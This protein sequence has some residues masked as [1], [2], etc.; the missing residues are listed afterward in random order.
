[1]ADLTICSGETTSLTISAGPQNVAGTTF[2]WTA[3]PSA[4]VS[5]SSSGNGSLIS[6]T[7]QTTNAI[8]GSVSYSITPTA[9]GCNGP[10]HVLTVTV[11]PIATVSAGADFAVCEPVSFE[12]KGFLG[13][14]AT[15]GNWSVV[16]PASGSLSASTT[17][18]NEV[19][20]I[21]TISSADIDGVITFRLT[22]NDPD[23]A[24]P[25]VSVS[26]DVNVSINRRAVV[27]LPA[28]YTLCEP[29]TIGLS[30]TLSGSATSAIW[31]TASTGGLSTTSI[32]GPGPTYTAAATYNT[33]AADVT[34]TLTFRLTTNDPDASGPCT[35]EFAEIDIHINESAKVNADLL[36]PICD[37]DT[38]LLTGS[39]SGSA[40]SAVWTAPAGATGI[41]QNPASLSTEYYHTKSDLAMKTLTFTLTTNDPDGAGP[42]VSSSDDVT[43]T[44]NKLDPVDL[45]NLKSTYA[46]NE[47]I[48]PLIAFPNDPD[49]GSGVFTGPGIIAGTSLFDPGNA[50]A[51]ATNIITYTWQN[52]F[53]GCINS[54]SDTTI[55]NALTVID[56]TIVGSTESDPTEI[57]VCR[58]SG[59]LWIKGSPGIHDP[60]TNESLSEFQSDEIPERLLQLFNPITGFT[61]YYLNTDG[62]DP[63]GF[64]TIRYYHVD[65]LGSPQAMIKRIYVSASPVADITMGPACLQD[66]VTFLQNSTFEPGLNPE[67]DSVVQYIW[68]FDENGE[69]EIVNA[70]I[71]SHPTYTYENAGPHLV[72]LT[73]ET[74]NGCT[75]TVT[76]VVRIGL[77]PKLDFGWTKICSGLET[78]IFE[79]KSVANDGFSTIVQYQWD[80]GDG[81][82]VAAAGAPTDAFPTGGTYED[83]RHTFNTYQ[84]YPVTLSALT[85]DG[86]LA[87]TT[88]QVY[89]LSYETPLATT[90]Y[91]ND[92][93]I[94]DG[95]WVPLPLADVDT[96]NSWVWGPVGANTITPNSSGPNGWWTGKNTPAWNN[97]ATYYA[98]ENS[99]LIGPCMNLEN[100]DRPM[101]SLDYWSD[102]QQGFDGLV[103]QY[104]T[105][106]AQSWKEIGDAEGSGINWYNERDLAT[107]PGKQDN[108]AWSGSTEGW[109]TARFNLDQIEVDTL[110]VFRLAFASNN[111]NPKTG[112]GLEGFAFDNIYI[113][114]KQKMVLVEH[115]TNDNTPSAARDYFSD[116]YERELAKKRASDFN[117]IQY[118]LANEGP[119]AINENNPADPFARAQWYGVSFTS[120]AIM[121]GIQGQYFG[122]TFNGTY[123]LIDSVELDRRA[124]EDPMFTITPSID[125]NPEGPLTGSVTFVYNG[126]NPD[127]NPKILHAVLVEDSVLLSGYHMNAVRK[128]L[129]EPQGLR[130]EITWTTGASYTADI[131]FNMRTAVDQ[132]E[133]LSL[134]I[135]VQDKNTQQILQSIVV[136]APNKQGDPI[137]GV[138]ENPNGT[139]LNKLKV[140]PVPASATLNLRMDEVL[141]RNYE[142]QIIDSR[143]VELTKGSLNRDLRQGQSIDITRIPNGIYFL[144]I[145]ASD[146]EVYY[147]KIAVMNR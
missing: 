12:V 19:T 47:A 129:W 41:I 16:G 112:S 147:R 134:V 75:S 92:F 143:G 49:L 74:N 116:L 85:D 78:T 138:P 39:L 107:S 81:T 2:A 25:C 37:Y 141:T 56:F 115:F 31:S 130:P 1:V 36:A 108:F 77:K 42:C 18:G 101:I 88:R 24:G 13:G 66:E 10:V 29:T 146:R 125:M 98:N 113:G 62:L 23:T 127:P 44:I 80:F 95:S 61:E 132:P 8:V 142:W 21:Y 123:S 9:N 50:N 114:N 53:T 5:G 137:T 124:L 17:T 34:N 91:F 111:D 33:I 87:D 145:Q 102:T 89:I 40:T 65:N 144:R 57:R 22:T 51:G 20:A 14:A 93:E 67:G 94:N 120:T 90:G 71:T 126:V 128:L 32:V 11:N 140:Y 100:L 30:G 86:C 6:Q 109:R 106:G 15:T 76:E 45:V 99:E 117:I 103:L 54:D 35:A 55:V 68:D 3:T 27:T 105:D 26:D 110:V 121:D 83:P 38:A 84:V 96:I 139:D 119:D 43:L 58:N 59:N 52:S 136:E 122:K 131:N 104:S 28:D 48:H 97:H 82:A 46:E 118:H 73:V 72:S 64:Y 63:N 60:I 133:H 135:F 70:P 4:N 7:L 79:N 69:G